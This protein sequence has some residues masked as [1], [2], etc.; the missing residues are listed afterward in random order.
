[1]GAYGPRKALDAAKEKAVLELAKPMSDASFKAL[2]E[3]H[4]NALLG[5]AKGLKAAT[6]AQD[7]G[8]TNLPGYVRALRDPK[9]TTGQV[10][11]TAAKDQWHNMPG[12]AKAMTVGIPAIDMYQAA[13]ANEDVP[14]MPG[15]A[16][17]FGRAAGGAA[18][19]LTLGGLPMMT[20][21]AAQGLVSG[22]AGKAGRGV[23]F[24]RKKFRGGDGG[25]Q[26][27][28]DNTQYGGETVPTERIMSD[29]AQG[30]APESPV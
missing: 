5:R 13:Q 19:G 6:E 28:K 22:A 30:I 4:T 25:I 11:S 29:R 12:W 21:M 27:P 15:K 26:A 20:G 24:M 14:N 23:D 18:A 16:E 10:L 3:K 9:H 8:L 17:R 2:N 1:M 7:M